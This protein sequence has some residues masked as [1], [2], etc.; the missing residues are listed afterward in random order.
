MAIVNVW[1]PPG[2]WGPYADLRSHSGGART[3]T[4]VNSRN[5]KYRTLSF[6]RWSLTLQLSNIDPTCGDQLSLACAIGMR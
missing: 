3:Y 1:A 2:T 4:G 5:G 6:S